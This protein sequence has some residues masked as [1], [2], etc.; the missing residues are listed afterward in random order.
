MPNNPT[1]KEV[2]GQVEHCGNKY[3]SNHPRYVP[4]APRGKG[5]RAKRCARKAN[6][7]VSTES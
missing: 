4:P 3:C 2:C 6:T 5:R 7:E 1:C